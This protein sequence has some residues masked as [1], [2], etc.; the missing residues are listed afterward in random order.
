M[1][2]ATVCITDCGLRNQKYYMMVLFAYLIGWLNSSPIEIKILKHDFLKI[3]RVRAWA[4]M[5]SGMQV[6]MRLQL[7]MRF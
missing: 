3:T 5:N 7:N 2:K 4:G 1:K 6:H